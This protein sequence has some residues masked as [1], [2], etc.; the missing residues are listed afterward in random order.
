MSAKTYRVLVH[1]RVTGVGFRYSALDEAERIGGL[2]GWIRNADARTVECLVQGEDAEVP[3]FLAWLRAGPPGA[4]VRQCDIEEIA[5]P[6][7]LE[8][9]H[10][11]A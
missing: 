7:R 6:P 5:R 3:A 2:C 10:I 9:F 11:R 8:A 4:V 1:G